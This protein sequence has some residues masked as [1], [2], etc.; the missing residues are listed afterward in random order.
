MECIDQVFNCFERIIIYICNCTE[1]DIYMEMKKNDDYEESKPLI[2]RNISD[3]E[4]QFDMKKKCKIIYTNEQIVAESGDT[5]LRKDIL[6]LITNDAP[7]ASD[8]LE[9]IDSTI[10]EWYVV[11]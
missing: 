8:V 7:C 10:N 9:K 3:I 2:N 5:D 4:N 6:K 11:S 1:S